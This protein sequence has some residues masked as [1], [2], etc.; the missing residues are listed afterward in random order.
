MFRLN[1]KGFSQITLFTGVFFLGLVVAIIMKTIQKQSD[2]LN[3]IISESEIVTYSNKL[4]QYLSSPKNCSATFS[5]IKIDEGTV[6]SIIVLKD[7]LESKRFEIYSRSNKTI[8]SQKLRIEE[9][10]IFDYSVEEDED[11]GELGLVNLQVKINKG[12]DN[13]KNITTNTIRLYIKSKDKKIVSCAFGGLPSDSRTIQ[14]KGRYIFLDTESLSINSQNNFG[15]LNVEGMIN[16]SSNDLE[17]TTSLKGSLRYNSLNGFFEVCLN[18]P[19][20]EKAHK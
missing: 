2:N 18:S 8:G 6:N 9:Y 7:G 4:K 14:D 10:K 15:L 17:C 16:L 12:K 11:L 20:W 5:G 13:F 3:N 19:S 1:N